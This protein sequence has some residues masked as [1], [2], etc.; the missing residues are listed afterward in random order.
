M[1]EISKEVI[2]SI[3]KEMPVRINKFL[4]DAGFCSRREADRIINECRVLIDGIPAQLGSKVIP[5][6]V[7]EADGKIL[8]RKS[9]I[10]L[11]AFNKPVGVECTTDA[12]NPDNIVDFINYPERIY[13]IGRLDKNS[14]GLILLTNTGELVNEILKSSKKHEKEYIV[15]LA[16]PVTDEFLKKMRNGVF[17]EELNVKTRQCR[18]EKI[19]DRTIRIV[20][21]QGL[22][23]Q[24][25]R[26]C[27][28][29]SN[30]VVTL[31][32]V[33][34]MNINLGSLEEG[35]YRDVS[36]KEIYELLS[37]LFLNNER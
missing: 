19:N 9:E 23:R 37:E 6:Q 24:I 13:P 26:M 14:S 5:G 17:L 33:R 31:K 22:N 7:V 30:R 27:A 21:T 16:K 36:Q 8:K 15:G 25:R 18:V 1:S 32:R 10:I 11:I 34:I 35:R 2:K 29:L 20:L 28:A 12:E 4:S 3:D